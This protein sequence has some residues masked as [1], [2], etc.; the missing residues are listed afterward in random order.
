MLLQA[1][2]PG[3]RSR[4]QDSEA[5]LLSASCVT[6]ARCPVLWVFIFSALKWGRQDCPGGP[7]VKTP[8]F[9]CRGH[10]FDPWLGTKIPHAVQRGQNFLKRWGGEGRS[11]RH[12]AAMRLPGPH[13][14]LGNEGPQTHFPQLH[15]GLARP[16]G[17]LHPATNHTSHSYAFEWG[18]VLGNLKLGTTHRAPAH[19]RCQVSLAGLSVNT[20]PHRFCIFPQPSL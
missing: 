4:G 15:F 1:P 13:H 16:S 8:R 10:G 6:K 14:L 7:V 17:G 18:Q 2:A 3:V 19:G 20:S 12:R 9:H 11:R 5:A